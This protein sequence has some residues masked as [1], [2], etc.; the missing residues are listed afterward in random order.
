ML[1]LS[2]K[3]RLSLFTFYIIYLTIIPRA[4]MG[5][6]SI[7][8]EAEGRMGYW[9]R[10]HEGERNNCLSKIQ[11]VGQKHRDKTTLASKTRFSRHCFELSTINMLYPMK[12]FLILLHPYLSTMADFFCPQGGRCGEVQ[13]TF[14]CI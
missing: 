11:L 14:D 12:R 5:S 6:E 4:R 13:L 8:H 1:L 3:I 10:G 7:A 2:T 9:L